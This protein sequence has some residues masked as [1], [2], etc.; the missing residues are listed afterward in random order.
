MMTEDKNKQFYESIPEGYYD[1]VYNKKKGVQSK[2]HQLKFR[3]INNIIEKINPKKVLDV[4][5]GPG[6]FLGQLP[7]KDDSV[8]FGTDIADNQIKF[9]NKKYSSENLKFK[10][11][12]DAKYPFDDNY[13]DVITAIEF[14][15]HISSESFDTNLNEMKRCL[16]KDGIIILTTPNYNSLWPI[17]EYIVSKVTSQNYIEQHI[18]KYNISKLHQKIKDQNFTDINISSY[19][20]LSPFLSIF[21]NSFSDLI[22]KFESKYFQKLGNLIICIFKNEK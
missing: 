9:A 3:K 21:S 18:S 4:A 8:Y 16:K 17:L 11:S 5:C 20:W 2:W 19:L 7:K 13:F 10:V 15:E 22:Y 14:I 12:E 1:Q 6:T